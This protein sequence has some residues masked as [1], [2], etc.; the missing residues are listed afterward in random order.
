LE[1]VK[2]NSSTLM[3]PRLICLHSSR[4]PRWNMEG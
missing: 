2:C 4:L 1:L 3:P